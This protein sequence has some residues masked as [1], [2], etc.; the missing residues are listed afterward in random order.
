M[1]Y[2]QVYQSFTTNF[3]FSTGLV[4][5]G[6]LQNTIDSFRA[7]TG[8]NLTDDNYPYLKHNATLVFS[9][10]NSSSSSSSSL[11]RRGLDTAILFARDGTD[12]SVN[13]QSES[14]GGNSGGSSN[15]SGAQ[16]SNEQ[17]FVS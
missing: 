16:S 3:A 5:W 7:K 13:G 12:V 4:S 10:S 8:G 6:Q 17:H 2:P 1:Q 14:I 11:L 9:G 15:S